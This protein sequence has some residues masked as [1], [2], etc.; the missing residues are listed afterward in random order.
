VIRSLWTAKGEVFFAAHC[1]KPSGHR[2]DE[3]KGEGAHGEGPRYALIS[4]G[5]G[6]TR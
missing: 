4:R 1:E 3:K 5:K 6:G 2:L